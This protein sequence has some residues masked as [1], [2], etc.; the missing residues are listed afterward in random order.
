MNDHR[1]HPAWRLG[2]HTHTHT[3]T[4]T[5]PF[6]DFREA[7]FVPK[8]PNWN[9]ATKLSPLRNQPFQGSEPLQEGPRA[10]LERSPIFCRVPSAGKLEPAPP[11][12]AS[13]NTEAW[14]RMHARVH[15]LKIVTTTISVIFISS[16][17]P[18]GDLVPRAQRALQVHPTLT[19]ADPS[20]SHTHT[21][22]HTRARTHIPTRPRG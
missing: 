11:A 7:A 8:T 15:I 22:T 2:G 21:H 4:H 10:V 5:H 17:L 12:P 18:S 19:L 3:H 1:L 6:L 20:L 9:P 16:H 14:T 13:P